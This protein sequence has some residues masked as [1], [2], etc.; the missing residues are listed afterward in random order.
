MSVLSSLTASYSVWDASPRDG[1]IHGQDNSLLITPFWKL[2]HRHT[3][4]MLFHSDSQSLQVYIK[5]NH[6]TM[7]KSFV[8]R[9]VYDVGSIGSSLIFIMNT[10]PVNGQGIFCLPI[11]YPF[12]PF[13]KLGLR[14]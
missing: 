9:F 10:I 11:M 5:I 2:L 3:Q 12:K 6:T 4:T 8:L 7:F 13:F 1:I 14:M